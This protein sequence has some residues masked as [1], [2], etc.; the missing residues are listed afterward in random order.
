M[1]SSQPSHTEWLSTVSSRSARAKLVRCAIAG[2]AL[3]VAG[4]GSSLP[5]SPNAGSP[6]GF[7][8]AAFKYAACMRAHGLASFPDPTMTDHNGQQVAYLTASIPVHPSPAFAS[9]QTACR[10]ILPTPSDVSQ[11]Q[12]AQQRQA[13]ARQL[14]AFARC[15][16]SHGI[17]D[18]PDPT[19][20][21][22]L[23]PAMVSSAGVDLHSQ[24][25]L[26][27]AKACIRTAHGAVTTA[28]VQRAIED[29]P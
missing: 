25:V 4:C 27:A 24:A 10:E 7:T 15:L 16:R 13:R 11:A 20:L 2:L 23:T 19:N 9:A 21:G 26:I 17:S 5:A 3:V 29:S 8:A 12:L 14:L 1:Q 6:T 22:Q 18:F 28:D